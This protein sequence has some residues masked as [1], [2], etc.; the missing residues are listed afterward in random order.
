MFHVM[1][2]GIVMESQIYRAY[3]QYKLSYFMRHI[4]TTTKTV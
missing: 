1:F 2:E 4:I 3:I